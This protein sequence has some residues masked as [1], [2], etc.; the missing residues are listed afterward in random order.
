MR[1]LSEVEAAYCGAVLDTDGSIGHYPSKFAISVTNQ[2][3]EVLSALLRAT[4]VGSV[5]YQQAGVRGTVW[6]WQLQNRA[7]VM[8]FA[9]Q[10]SRYST[11]A[12]A[13]IAC[14]AQVCYNV[15]TEPTRAAK[16]SKRHGK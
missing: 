15:D 5:S 10:V 14:E 3:L 8:D 12:Q 13:F 2:N 6:Q 16:G 1:R 7:G 9:K 4:Q 11:K